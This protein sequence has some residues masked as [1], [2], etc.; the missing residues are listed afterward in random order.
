MD[1]KKFVE[2]TPKTL[3]INSFNSNAARQAKAMQ[4]G[5]NSTLARLVQ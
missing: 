4:Y 3:I 5:K 1:W 2:N